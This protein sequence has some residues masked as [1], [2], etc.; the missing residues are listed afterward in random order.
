MSALETERMGRVDGSRLTELRALK[1]RVEEEIRFE[2]ARRQGSQYGGVVVRQRISGDPWKHELLNAAADHFD[3]DVSTVV[4]K[5]RVAAVV[6]ARW[7]VCWVARQDGMTT[8]AIGRMVNQDHSI[9]CR[10][11]KH[12]EDDEE[13]LAIAEGIAARV[14]GVRLSA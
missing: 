10:A 8:P 13:L 9:A 12:V 6:K 11:I 7:V 4:G 1:K 3:V 2:E 5:C 14:N